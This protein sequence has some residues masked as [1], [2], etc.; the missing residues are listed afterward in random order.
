MEGLTPLEF[1]VRRGVLTEY[2][3]LRL[4]AQIQELIVRAFVCGYVTAKNDRVQIRTR[5]PENESDLE[6]NGRMI[7]LLRDNGAIVYE[8]E[9]TQESP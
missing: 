7:Q 2:L 4:P 9:K 6:I 1:M 5:T 8:E 3:A